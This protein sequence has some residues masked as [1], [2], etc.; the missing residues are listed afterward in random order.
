M[1]TSFA[2]PK[3]AADITNL[4]LDLDQEGTEELSTENIIEL[5]SVDGISQYSSLSE[6][7]S[8]LLESVLGFNPFYTNE[9][10]NHNKP[11]SSTSLERMHPLIR[12][13]MMPKPMIQTMT[14][15]LFCLRQR[16]I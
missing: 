14:P 15:H 7:N 11:D 9:K 3:V 16:C 6:V 12:L 2:T 13:S 4:K 1:G 8:E 10:S 5:I